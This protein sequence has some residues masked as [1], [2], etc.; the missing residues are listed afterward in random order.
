MQAK[1]SKLEMNS[2]HL[3]FFFNIEKSKFKIKNE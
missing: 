1:L 2:F 3:Q